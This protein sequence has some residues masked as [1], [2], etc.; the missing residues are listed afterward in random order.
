MTRLKMLCLLAVA[1]AIATAL[2]GSGTAAADIVCTKNETPCNN[3]IT[4]IEA[5]IT[6]NAKFTDTNGNTVAECQGSKLIWNI[7]SHESGKAA[8]GKL[9]SLTWAGCT[10]GGIGVTTVTESLGKLF[11][12]NKTGST[13]GTLEDEGTLVTLNLPLFGDCSYGFGTTM[14][15][16]FLSGGNPTLGV[17]SVVNKLKGPEACPNSLKLTADY[18]I[19]NHKEAYVHTN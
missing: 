7:E 13:N 18:A 14:F 3:V 17:N 11:V 4:K 8:N 15:G 9:S 19:T 1:T 16:T 6:A 10:I 2:I 5:S 12:K